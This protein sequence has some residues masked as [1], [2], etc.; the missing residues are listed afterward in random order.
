MALL[1]LYVYLCNCI[2]QKYFSRFVIFFSLSLNLLLANSLHVFIWTSHNSYWIYYNFFYSSYV[3]LLSNF[4][5]K[6]SEFI[7]QAGA[8]E[9]PEVLT[10][11]NVT[12]KDEG[13]YTCIAQNTLGE[14]FSSA[15]LAVVESTCQNTFYFYYF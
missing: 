7:L 12:E 6:K 10:L 13:W 9:N 14:T 1:I 5:F 3:S 11:H 15:Y 2:I 8:A 4:I